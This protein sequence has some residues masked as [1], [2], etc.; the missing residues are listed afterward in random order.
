MKRY[1]LL[2]AL[3]CALPFAAFSQSLK[4]TAPAGNFGMPATSLRAA[5]PTTQEINLKLLQSTLY[6]Q[7]NE[8]PRYRRHQRLRNAGIVLFAS[9][10]AGLFVGGTLMGAGEGFGAF[11]AGLTLASISGALFIPGIVLWGVGQ[12]RMDKYAEAAYEKQEAQ[13]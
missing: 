5:A 6:E 8:I 10:L 9:S 12:E 1:I 7:L 2:A 3:L 4:L 13:K 11:A